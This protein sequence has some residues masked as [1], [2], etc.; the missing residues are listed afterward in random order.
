MAPYISNKPQA[1]CCTSDR[2]Y[3]PVVAVG[4]LAQVIVASQRHADEIWVK[5]V[6]IVESFLAQD[7]P[8]HLKQNPQEH[9][10]C[11]L[12]VLPAQNLTWEKF[13]NSGQH[14]SAALLTGLQT[15]G[16]LQPQLWN[17]SEFITKYGA[18]SVDVDD[19]R[20]DEFRRK[21][22]PVSVERFV[23]SM[24][25]TNQS[26]KAVGYFSA[27]E[28]DIMKSIIDELPDLMHDFDRR[29]VVQLAAGLASGT[30]LHN[31]AETW[32]ALVQGMKA[33]WVAP[34]PTSEEVNK[35][36]ASKYTSHPCT[37]LKTKPPAGLKL[38]IQQAG[39]VMYLGDGQQHATCNLMEFVLG[40]GSQGHLP[41]N[42]SAFRKALHRGQWTRAKEELDKDQK[43]YTEFLRGE[44]VDESSDPFED[45]ETVEI[46][47]FLHSAA[48]RNHVEMVEFLIALN[49]GNASYLEAV[50][51]KDGRQAMHHAANKG[52]LSVL[53]LLA[54]HRA[55]ITCKD[56]SDWQPMHLASFAGHMDFVDKL[57]NLGAS[58]TALMGEQQQP[59]HLASQDGHRDV[60]N[61]LASYGASIE[62][63]TQQGWQP[64][65]MATLNGHVDVVEYLATSVHSAETFDK[66]GF[67]PVHYAASEDHA[68]V[69]EMLAQNGVNVFAKSSQ[70]FSPMDIASSKG[71]T[72]VIQ[73][74][75]SLR[76]GDDAI[77]Q[78]FKEA[79]TNGDGVID[80]EEF[81]AMKKKSLTPAQRSSQDGDSP[82]W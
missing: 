71:H 16:V 1:T 34:Q 46:L 8:M 9:T 79:D 4:F 70:G 49:E 29:T 72:E 39:D 19:G 32:L 40:I 53:E 63:K 41:Q 18:Y 65:H 15:N 62:A 50:T 58:V 82:Q 55:S 22:F 67:L 77:S 7:L 17:R 24:V 37:W 31:H 78:E 12:P 6:E 27:L 75:Q 26:L 38:C 60:V 35:A 56:K 42:W 43:L 36:I 48:K 68:A 69:I 13:V 2:Y 44:F 3:F 59:M 14:H 11:E 76:T 5:P 73:L 51:K 80:A 64:M 54:S 52:H 81:A 66:Y 25:L 30:A 74:L 61:L 20:F 57:V 45:G 47:P 21:K 33:W 28:H 10:L 23:E